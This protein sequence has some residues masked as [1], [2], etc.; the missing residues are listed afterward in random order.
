MNSYKEII[1]RFVINVNID[2]FGK[3]FCHPPRPAKSRVINKTINSRNMAP[4]QISSNL[5]SFLITLLWVN[6][7]KAN[8]IIYLMLPKLLYRSLMIIFILVVWLLSLEKHM[9]NLYIG[10]YIWKEGLIMKYQHKM[11]VTF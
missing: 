5:L 3:R 2:P 11:R 10:I 6:I 7:L 1:E 9:K 4:I 8:R